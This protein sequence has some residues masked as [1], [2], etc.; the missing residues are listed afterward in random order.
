[1]S[2]AIVLSKKA[3]GIS[4]PN[5]CVGAVVVKDGDAVG[6]GWTGPPGGPHAE[7]MALDQAG[8]DATGADMYVTLE[9]CCH[10]GRTGPCTEAIIK[11]GIKTVY[12]SVLD[13]NPSVNGH[14]VSNLREAGLDV[15][16]GLAEKESISVM[17]P[18]L[19]LMRTGR[20]FVTV[21]FAISLDGKIAA[22]SGESKWITGVKS[23]QYTHRLRAYSDAV[24]VGINTV[25]VDYP[26]LTARDGSLPEGFRQPL[27]V[28]VDSHGRTPVGSAICNDEASTL[29]ATFQDETRSTFS[30]IVSVRSFSGDLG[31]VDLN[32]LLKYLGDI[33]ISSVL[34]EG[35]SE[36][37]GSLFDQDLVD[38]VFAFVAPIIIGGPTKGAVGGEGAY[39]MSDVERLVDVELK[40]FDQDILLTGYCRKES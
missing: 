10:F 27:R 7:I 30:D 26:E 32:M 24:M 36:L 6:E 25:L 37:I 14:G 29:I 1:M 8:D 18:H 3:L 5:P 28:V 22:V 12:I 2:S 39:H 9:P 4:T 20:P 17:E 35:G 23:R 38:K 21:K 31:R 16:I 13:P 11:A 19:K 33:S 34:V 40:K 15:S